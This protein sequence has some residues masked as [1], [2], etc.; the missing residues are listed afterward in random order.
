[1]SL[2]VTEIYGPVFQGEGPHVGRPCWFMR[3][4][5]C[6]LDCAWCDTPYTW[7][8][9]EYNLADESPPMSLEGIRDQLPT[10]GLVVLTGG[11]PLMHRNNPTLRTLLAYDNEP[12]VHVET[13]G[14]L[15]PPLWMVP[16]VAWWNVSPKLASSGVRDSKRR[17]PKVLDFFAEAAHTKRACF[18]FVATDPTDLDEVA[19]IV[20]DFDIPDRA[21][22]IM[23]E[24]ITADTQLAG[25]RS[26]ADDVAARGW[27]LTPRLHV[28][29]HNDQRGV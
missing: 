11:E 24:G 28:L 9:S 23:A 8:K 19:T 25:M 26:L 27:N 5:N 1:M 14:T 12:E 13:N 29:L 21:V 6:N 3:L 7:D 17:K 22:W 10:R 15:L 18:K 4:G 20:A 16:R 2:P